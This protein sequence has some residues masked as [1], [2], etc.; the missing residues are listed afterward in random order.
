MTLTGRATDPE[1][2]TAEEVGQAF[3]MQGREI[4]TL[5]KKGEF[6][7]PIRVGKEERWRTTDL[8][9]YL[10]IL[11]HETW[12]DQ[13]ELEY[14]GGKKT[15]AGFIPPALDPVKENLLTACSSPAVYFLLK[16]ET[17]IYVGS[18]LNPNRRVKDHAAG[19]ATTKQK[20]FDRV[21]ML[22][23]PLGELLEAE[24]KFVALLDPPLNVNLKP[25]PPS[26][27]QEAAAAVVMEGLDGE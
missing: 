3:R 2:L 14:A 21:L 12:Q 6:P 23:V 25:K 22:P 19:T 16:F 15:P 13:Q 24:K 27:R 4:R 1:V 10:D 11:S 9:K 18:S 26:R 8:W 7:A 5:V 20:D 17:V